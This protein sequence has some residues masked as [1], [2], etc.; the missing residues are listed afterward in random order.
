MGKIISKAN[1]SNCTGWEDL[2]RY[3]SQFLQDCATQVNGN[4]TVTDN[5]SQR[6]VG[7]TFTA[8]NSTLIV[9]HGLGRVPTMW[10]SGSQVGSTAVISETKP[11][12]QNNVYLAASAVCGAKILVI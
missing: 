2:M 10:L 9:A 3:V 5:L 8:A 12:D 4:L 6:V 1:V 7:A 11:A